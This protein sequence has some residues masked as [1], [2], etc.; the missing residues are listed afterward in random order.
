LKQKEK[1]SKEKAVEKAVEKVRIDLKNQ[2]DGLKNEHAKAKADW[3]RERK[4]LLSDH[5]EATSAIYQ[6]VEASRDNEVRQAKD[7]VE[8]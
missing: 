2:M 6:E 3:Q 7:R 1:A 8:K 5:E 4:K